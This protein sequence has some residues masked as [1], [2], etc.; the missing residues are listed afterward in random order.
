MAHDTT[1]YFDAF[2]DEVQKWL[3]RFG[4]KSWAVRV[5]LYAPPPRSGDTNRAITSCQ[6][7]SRRA[8]I[9]LVSPW[10][11]WLEE[12]T[13]YL[14]RKSAF[15]EVCEL[16]LVRLGCIA[17]NLAARGEDWE[18]ETHVIIRTLENAVFDRE[19]EE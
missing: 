7:L 12:P 9:C 16:L 11:S 15:H 10:P 19:W 8:E 2:N 6:P 3:E 1:P 5:L 18:E 13:E 4:L 14:V 17:F